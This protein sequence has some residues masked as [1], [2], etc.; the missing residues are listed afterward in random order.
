M[1]TINYDNTTNSY[2][3]ISNY[4]KNSNSQQLT[5]NYKDLYRNMHRILDTIRDINI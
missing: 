4:I 5:F 3:N 2:I 1:R